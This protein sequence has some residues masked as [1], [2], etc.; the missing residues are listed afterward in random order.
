M[1]SATF[2]VCAPFT[3]AIAKVSFQGE[4]AGVPA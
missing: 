2:L 4:R 1:G 3:T